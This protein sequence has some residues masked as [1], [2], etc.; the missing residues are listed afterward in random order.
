MSNFLWKSYTLRSDRW[1]EA[2]QLVSWPVGQLASWSSGQLVSWPAGQLAS[3][4]HSRQHPNIKK[5]S[6]PSLDFPDFK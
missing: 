6:V 5:S 1:K 4:Q 2:G 3:R